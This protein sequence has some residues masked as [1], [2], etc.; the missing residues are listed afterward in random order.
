[1]RGQRRLRIIAARE[2]DEDRLERRQRTNTGCRSWQ[3]TAHDWREKFRDYM[4]ECRTAR[5][6]ATNHLTGHGWWCWIIPLR[7]GD[8]SAGIVYDSRI[9]K[10]AEGTNLGDR[11]RAH[12]L[13]N[14]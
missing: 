9:F 13:A 5:S 7:G 12:L 1:M 6:W 8:V 14:P 3:R 10:L 4:D 11:L 2:S